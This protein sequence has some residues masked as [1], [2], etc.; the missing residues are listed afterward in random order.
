ML[1]RS[2]RAIA[3]GS[4]LKLTSRS[5]RTAQ[6]L[7]RRGKLYAIHTMTF[8]TLIAPV[9]GAAPPIN[10]PRGH[11]RKARNR[12][13][14]QLQQLADASASVTRLNQLQSASG[15]VMQRSESGIKRLFPA[16]G[17][18]T[19][20]GDYLMISGNNNDM[21]YHIRVD[22][23]ESDTVPKF[24]ITWENNTFGRRAHFYY[25]SGGGRNESGLEF[26]AQN[27]DYETDAAASGGKLPTLDT[28]GGY[29]DAIATT[30]VSG[31]LK[32]ALAR[33]EQAEAAL[34]DRAQEQED[35][36]LGKDTLKINCRDMPRATNPW[37]AGAG[38]Q[39]YSKQHELDAIIDLVGPGDWLRQEGQEDDR[40]IVLR[41]KDA[42][43]AGRAMRKL[44]GEAKMVVA[45]SA[46]DTEWPFMEEG[47]PLWG[48]HE[49]MNALHHSNPDA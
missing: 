36:R 7:T 24:H 3:R 14:S 39:Y 4:K 22:Y 29:A 19:H 45:R 18:T 41:Y 21:K 27:R 11:P 25:G 8:Q 31:T 34:S 1:G 44:T 49:A 20:K 47:D 46:S 28:L 10:A 32:D 42:A 23:A 30:F 13:L 48:A 35:V 2:V 12:M 6:G 17:T 16:S 9:L 40:T 37:G 43:Q 5:D 26:T 38:V 33:V 15:A